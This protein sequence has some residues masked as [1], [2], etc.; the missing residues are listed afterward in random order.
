MYINVFCYSYRPSTCDHLESMEGKGTN[1][2]AG[3][4]GWA[5]LLSLIS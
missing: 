5:N 4:L 2:V 3:E 1:A